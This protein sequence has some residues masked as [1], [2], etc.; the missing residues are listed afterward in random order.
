MNRIMLKSKI[1]RATLTG[2]EL[3]YEGSITIDKTLLDKANILVNEQVQVLNI[4]TGHRFMTYTIEAPADSGIIMLNGPAARLGAI[5]DRL[6]IISYCMVDD[7]ESN[8]IQPIVV[9]V[10]ENNQSCNT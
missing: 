3:N 5:G 6:I 10:D 8:T 9:R 2:T 7:K 1:H 4:H